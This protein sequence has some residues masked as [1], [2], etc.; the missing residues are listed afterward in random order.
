MPQVPKLY[1]C[2]SARS[3]RS[4]FC[5][6][7]ALALA[8]C[9]GN[10]FVVPKPDASWQPA[11]T[12]GQIAVVQSV[13]PNFQ[14]ELFKPG[15][16]PNKRTSLRPSNFQ[17]AMFFGPAS[18]QSSAFTTTAGIEVEARGFDLMSVPPVLPLTAPYFEPDG[19][20]YNLDFRLQRISA[21]N[22]IEDRLGKPLTSNG[23]LIQY[24]P[25]NWQVSGDEIDRILTEVQ[26]ALAVHLPAVQNVPLR[27]CRIV[28]E[29]TIFF[30]TGSNY[31]TTWAVGLTRDPSGGVYTLHLTLFYVNGVRVQ[32]DWRRVLIDEGINFF[33]IAIGRRGLAR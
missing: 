8:S 28:I 23:P 30:F 21:L 6:T 13:F 18:T 15:T 2:F 3:V 25:K 22:K 11:M 17:P 4:L 33:V 32:N 29:P 26:S 31:G 9:Q 14:P 7:L 24:D 20:P 27:N 12:A 5:L 16:D 19:T 10:K 1:V